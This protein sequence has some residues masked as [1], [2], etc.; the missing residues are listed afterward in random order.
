V[1]TGLDI[2][3]PK[4]WSWSPL[5]FTTTFLN[6]GS[7]PEYVDEGPVRAISQA[8]N[9]L[10]GLDWTRT[11]FS[12]Y[13][14][15]PRRLK[16][17]LLNGDTLINST[18][19]GTLGRVGYFI[20]G[21]DDIPCVADSHVTLARADR[22][23][24]KSRYLYY[25]LS[26]TLF[27]NFIYSALVVGATNQIE[28]NR[29]GLAGAPIALPPLGEQGRI[30]NFLDTETTRIDGLIAA[31]QRM[32]ELLEERLQSLIASFYEE[33]SSS[34]GSVAISRLCSLAVD[35]VNKTAPL[36]DDPTDFRMLRTTNVKCGAVDYEGCS[37]VTA[38]TFRRWNRRATPMSG[39]VLL[40]REAPVGEVGILAEDKPV[41]LGQRL[42]LFRAD[43]RVAHPEYLL[44][45]LRAPQVRSA[46]EKFGLGSTTPHLKVGQCLSIPIPNAQLTIQQ[47]M[48]DRL[49]LLIGGHEGIRRALTVQV[50]LLQERRQALITAAVT[51]QID[52]P[53]SA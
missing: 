45:M 2:T 6:R 1:S 41:I 4:S 51:G 12:A 47:H 39:D 16:G 14:G 48:L 36:S 52:I 15:D 8:A 38:E 17:Y 22:R 50:A 29:E 9:Q 25:W 43:V 18:G 3:I 20:E 34:Y 24:V 28:L 10:T 44:A 23:I 42:M 13:D 35:C 26:S 11:R 5:K 19:N 27:Y 32:A 31:K 30:A 21:P 7:A 46:V 40:T 49:K 37:F 33:F 53:G